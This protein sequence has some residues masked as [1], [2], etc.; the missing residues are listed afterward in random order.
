MNP[1][2]DSETASRALP[3]ELA[4]VAFVDIRDVVSAVCMSASWI[5]AEVAADRFPK[6][7]RFG[8]RCSRWTRASIRQYLIDRAAQAVADPASGDRLVA[9]AK[10][11]SDAAK[12]KRLAAQGAK[13]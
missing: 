4:D 10:K 11:A 9:K 7:L 12:V 2:P 13:S 3:P 6:P 1:K 8:S 5:H